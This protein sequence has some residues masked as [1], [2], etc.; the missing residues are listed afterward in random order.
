MERSTFGLRYKRHYLR[1]I[2]NK[3]GKEME[4]HRLSIAHVCS[5]RVPHDS[6]D[7]TRNAIIVDGMHMCINIIG[8]RLVAGLSCQLRCASGDKEDS[9]TCAEA[10]NERF[11][12]V[13]HA[14]P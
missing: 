3:R 2:N 8:S 12:N 14:L 10:C 9:W 7:C 6:E 13:N 5:E 11:M 4:N 1:G